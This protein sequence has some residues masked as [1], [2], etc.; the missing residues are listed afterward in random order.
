VLGGR[1]GAAPRVSLAGEIVMT[2]R[3]FYD[4]DAKYLGASG[5]DLVCPA[6]LTPAELAEMQELAAR[7]F[8]A[9]DGA[10]L[11]RVD[12]FLTPTGFVVNELN[13]MPGFTPISMFPTCWIAS[14]MTY[15]EIIDELIA[16]ALEDV[17][18]QGTAVEPAALEG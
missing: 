7:A 1:A 12:F 15:P 17:E 8:T 10:G 9:I 2:G 13:T 6:S 4:F 5:V 18:S 16:L 14:G 11:A 3:E